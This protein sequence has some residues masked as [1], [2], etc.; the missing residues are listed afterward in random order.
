MPRPIR[1]GETCDAKIYIAPGNQAMIM[2]K[3]NPQQV[4]VYLQLSGHSRS[5]QLGKSRDGG[6]MEQKQTMG[7]SFRG[8]V[9]KQKTY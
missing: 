7:E 6:I 3:H 1:E 8:R 9:D 4:Q 5:E 2:R